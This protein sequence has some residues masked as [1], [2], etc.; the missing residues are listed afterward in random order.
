MS[1]VAT[2][3]EVLGLEVLPP[4]L[5]ALQAAR[6]LGVSKQTIYRAV[7]DGELQGMKLRGR[8]VVATRPLLDTL[9]FG[10]D[11]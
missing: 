4:S 2:P 9:G 7:A 1:R 6:L 3:Q 10:G 5:T 11:E 8:L